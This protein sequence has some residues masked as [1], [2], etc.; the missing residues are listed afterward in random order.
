VRRSEEE[1]HGDMVRRRSLELRE[2]GD[3]TRNLVRKSEEAH[4][5]EEEI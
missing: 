4:L 1:G 3:I 2:E 5:C